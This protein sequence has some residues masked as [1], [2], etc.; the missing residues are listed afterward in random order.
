MIGGFILY[1]VREIVNYFYDLLRSVLVGFL[2]MSGADVLVA[3]PA[4]ECRG[5]ENEVVNASY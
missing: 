3:C 4:H 2:E 5:G 1:W